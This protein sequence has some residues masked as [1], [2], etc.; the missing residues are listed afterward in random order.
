MAAGSQAWTVFVRSSN[1]IV[2]SNPT[3]GMDVCIVCVYSVFVWS[4]VYEAAMWWVDNSSKVSDQLCIGL[5][6]WKTGQGPTK[7]CRA[8]DYDDSLRL[9]RGGVQL[10][11]LGRENRST[12]RKPAPAPLCPPQIPLVSEVGSRRLTAWAMARSRLRVTFM[13]F[14]QRKNNKLISISK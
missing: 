8:I 10:G 9:V 3:Q 2:G 7:G 14:L 13:H 12:R 11:P 6:N 4:C 1:G 5:R